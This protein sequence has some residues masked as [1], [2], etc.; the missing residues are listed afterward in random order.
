MLVW[1]VFAGAGWVAGSIMGLIPGNW[2][3][4]VHLVLA[5]L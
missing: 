2:S 1:L 5:C 4:A 3:F